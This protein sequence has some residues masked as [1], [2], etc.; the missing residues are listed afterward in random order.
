[1][2]SRPLDERQFLFGLES[3]LDGIDARLSAYREA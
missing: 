2:L 3:L 1:V